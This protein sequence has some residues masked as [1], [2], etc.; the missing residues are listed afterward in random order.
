[1]WFKDGNH[2]E[3]SF[4]ENLPLNGTIHYKEHGH[5]FEGNLSKGS[6]VFGTLNYPNG[7]TFDGDFEND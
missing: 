6:R 3:G 4:L 1:M 7:V 5:K 2:F